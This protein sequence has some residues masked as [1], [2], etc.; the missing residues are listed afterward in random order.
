MTWQLLFLDSK[1]NTS[2][3]YTHPRTWPRFR[4]KGK[5]L[6][7]RQQALGISIICAFDNWLPYREACRLAWD[8]HARIRVRE[9]VW[10]CITLHTKRQDQAPYQPT[11]FNPMI[12]YLFRTSL[13]EIDIKLSISTEFSFLFS[14]LHQIPKGRWNSCR[15]LP[16]TVVARIALELAC[17]GFS[18]MRCV[19]WVRKE[20]G[21][22]FGC[23]LW[24]NGWLD[25]RL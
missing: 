1:H 3:S 10:Q 6:T 11:I 23:N 25:E 8:Q 2:T 4:G 13:L 18:C 24:M 14:K 5:P 9:V 22:A 19:V 7:V 15:S 21:G 17:F 20:R 12:Q 16:C